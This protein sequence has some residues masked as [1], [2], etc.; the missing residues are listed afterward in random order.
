MIA[1]LFVQEAAFCQIAMLELV[2]SRALRGAGQSSQRGHW[3]PALLTRAGC[4][5][6]TAGKATPGPGCSDCVCA[7]IIGLFGS[8]A[9]LYTQL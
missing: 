8:T 6:P 2:S 1:K 7:E 5:M 4:S 3:A 9:I